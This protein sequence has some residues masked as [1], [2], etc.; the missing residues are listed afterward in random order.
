MPLYFIGIPLLAVILLNLG[1]RK[2]VSKQVA[3]YTGLAI[4][5]IQMA[6]AIYACVL[7]GGGRVSNARFVEKLSIDL[8]SGV[9]LFTIWV[10]RVYFAT[11]FQRFDVAQQVFLF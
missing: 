4:A 10:G 9:T 1:P 11:G 6:L 5:V 3:F 7:V 2:W 8:I